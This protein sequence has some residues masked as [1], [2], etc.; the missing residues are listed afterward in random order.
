MLQQTL[1]LEIGPTTEAKHAPESTREAADVLH[2][3]YNHGL[4]STHVSYDP[5]QNGQ[6]RAQSKKPILLNY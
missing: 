3:E 4:S 6:F 5:R 1:S 2:A